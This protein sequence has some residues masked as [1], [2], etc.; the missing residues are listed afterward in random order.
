MHI[1]LVNIQDATPIYNRKAI[2]IRAWEIMQNRPYN[3]TNM[4]YAMYQAWDEAKKQ[5]KTALDAFKAMSERRS[6]AIRTQIALL[7]NK[8]FSMDISKREAELKAEL[9]KIEAPTGP[10]PTTPAPAAALAVPKTKRDLINATGGELV[11]VDFT[12]K[13]ERPRTTHVFKLAA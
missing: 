3:K 6:D 2:M 8:P 9:A 4:R 12:K 11:V 10:N 5:A 1:E 13:D 7:Q